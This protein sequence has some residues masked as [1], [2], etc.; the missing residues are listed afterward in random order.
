MN[1]VGRMRISSKELARISLFIGEEEWREHSLLVIGLERFRH[2]L[3]QII[4]ALREGYIGAGCS[5]LTVSQY[6]ASPGDLT[7]VRQHNLYG[8]ERI[9]EF[10]RTPRFIRHALRTSGFC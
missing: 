5:S 8:L 3:Q 2:L 6:P 7:V 10:C 4:L 1:R 9:Y